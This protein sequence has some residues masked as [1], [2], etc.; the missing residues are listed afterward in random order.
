MSNLTI[1]KIETTDNEHW[2]SIMAIYREAFPEWE[3]EPEE[4]IEQRLHSGRYALFSG[5]KNHAVIGFYIL[6]LNHNPSYALLCFLAVA[7]N[8]RGHGYGTLLCQDAIT[9]F[10]NKKQRDWL[11]TEAEDRQA[12]FYG[13]LGFKKANLPY[14]VP[15]FDSAGSI[16]MHLMLMSLDSNKTMVDNHCLRSLIHHTFT[17]G[18]DLAENDPRLARQLALIPE[19]TQLLQWPQ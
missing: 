5:Q 3:R 16:P 14:N 17:T 6:D 8:Y 11:L 2:P 9:R 15:K 10:H 12:I 1:T 7:E 13:K 4:A 19:K 18:Y